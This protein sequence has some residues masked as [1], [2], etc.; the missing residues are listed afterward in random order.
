MKDFPLIR[1]PKAAAVSTLLMV[2]PLLLLSG[3]ALGGMY[4]VLLVLYLLPTAA[5]LSAAVSGLMPM[6]LGNAAGLFAMYRLFGNQGLVLA[7]VY[8]LP[9][10]ALFLLAVSLRIPFRQACPAMIGVHAAVLAGCFLLVQSWTGG[11]LYEAAGEQAAALMSRWDLGDTMLYQLYS[12]GMID[13]PESLE[14]SALMPVLGGYVLSAAARQD[15]LLSLSTMITRTLS[16][17][18]PNVIVT[19]SILGGVACLLLPLRFGY[20]AAEKR[21]YLAAPR[22]EA[23]E[24]E[25]G[26]E[27]AP[28]APPVDFPTLDMPRFETWH[29]PR[30]MGWQVGLLLLAGYLLRSSAHPTAAIAGTV[31]YSAGHA[32]FSIQGA[33]LVNFMQKSKGTRRGWRVIV[34][35]LLLLFSL[36][37]FIGIFDQISNIRRLRKPREPKEEI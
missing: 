1:S 37:V 2:L 3:S 29:L 33:A 26:S 13:L 12:M 17:L 6:A 23:G 20:I 16:L 4:A 34:P 21:A 18:V 19:Q 8:L 35:I 36:L 28:A 5:C 31:L 15:L 32:I 27:A 9:I 14:G 10:L 24:G 30:G 22:K 11:R 25:V 7:S